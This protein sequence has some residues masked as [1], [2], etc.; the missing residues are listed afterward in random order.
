MTKGLPSSQ[1]AKNAIVRRIRRSGPGAHSWPRTSS[2]ANRGSIDMALSALLRDKIIRRIRRGLYDVPKMNPALGGILSPDID[3]TARTIARRYRW[4]IVPEGA[5]AANL[6]G[7]STQV[8]ARIVYLSD[9]PTQ[10][11][12]S[13]AGPFTSNTPARMSSE[14]RRG[15]PPRPS[16]R[17]GISERS[18]SMIT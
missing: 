18:V 9:G 17:F 3:Q 12:R 13:A 8:P 14:K 6:L 7:L 16:R 1:T 10:K 11:V 2:I 5:W 4:T 15:H